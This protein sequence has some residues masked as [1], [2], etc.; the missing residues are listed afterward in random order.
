MN[1][2]YSMVIQ[3]S[4]E[5]ACFVVSLPEFAELVKQPCT[6]GKTYEEAVQKGQEAIASLIEWL[7]AEGM[8]LPEPK[9]IPQQPLSVV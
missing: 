3:W 8:P 6:D 1:L 4:E 2:L 7:Q 9:T 5:D